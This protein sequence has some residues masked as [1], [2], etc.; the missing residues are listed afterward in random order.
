M[1]LTLTVLALS[2]SSS[3]AKA[4][5]DRNTLPLDG[6]ENTPT[7]QTAVAAPVLKSIPTTVS[8]EQVFST[9]AQQYK[10]SVTFID[11]W[12]TWCPPCRQAMK[13]VDLIKPALTAKGCKFVYVTGE[14]SP[15]ADF[16]TMYKTIEGDHFY[17]TD[18]QY[19]GLLGQFDVEG[20]P[21][22][23]LLDK[24]GKVIWQHT[25]YPGNDEVQSQIE[26]ALAK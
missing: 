22:Y 20:I 14:T 4:T 7:L 26:V 16:D 8:P 18:A 24:E 10:G 3:C 5:N 21:H 2:L 6:D 17:L 25:G 11:F 1:L 19:K 13:Q 23:I 15:R 9:I 12:A